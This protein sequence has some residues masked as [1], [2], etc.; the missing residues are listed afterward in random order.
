MLSSLFAGIS[1]LNANSNAMAVIGD[2]IANINTTGFKRSRTSF[3]NILSQSQSFVSR[4]EIG[5]GVHLD[6][7]T[8][9]MTQGALETTDSATDMAIQGTGFFVVRDDTNVSFYTRAGD[10]SFDKDGYLVDKNRMKVQ[11]WDL[12]SAIGTGG[13]ITDIV[14]PNGGNT[15]ANPTSDISLKLN[16]DASAEVGSE[17]YST[18]MTVYDSLGDAIDMTL[19][20]TRAAGGWDW[21]AAIPAADGTTASGGTLAFDTNGNLTNNA[22]ATI[23]LAL[24]TGATTP[25]T[26]TWDL[27][28]AA[29]GSNGDVTGYS[30][31]S[32]TTFHSQDG[33]PAGA[34]SNINIDESG[35][36]TGVYAN[37]QSSALF[38]MALA[39]FPSVS[40]LNKLGGNLYSET[41]ASGQP[42][43]GTAG[44]GV[45]GDIISQTLE[46][47]NVDLA[48][49]FVK[50]ITT[51]RAFQANSR[52]ITTSD[53]I[54]TEL[55]NIKR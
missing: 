22:D 41:L 30:S 51:Q 1:G 21:T 26:I 20:F 4:N 10:F 6:S 49:E 33:Y 48:T 32:M 23:D 11:G 16:L 8:T 3:A 2:N 29:G 24:L 19:T 25:H 27:V 17:P 50:L 47:S 52:V 34:L 5:R 14:I 36:I 45:M 44:N 7:I 55:I 13:Q 40:G 15:A 53:E 39:T 12:N 37:G 38:Q 9:E 54:L 43:L 28:D 46:M 42:V 18:S 35:F 31:K